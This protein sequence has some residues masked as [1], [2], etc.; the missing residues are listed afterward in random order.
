VKAAYFSPMPPERSGIA[1]YSA[2]LVPELAKRVELHVVERGARR[3]PRGTDA[4]VYHVGNDAEHH[5]WIVEALRGFPSLVVLHE[6]VL[7]HLVAGMTLGRGDRDGY[8][9]A[10]Q[11][12]AGPA[13]RMLAHGVVD[14]LV[15]PLWE[16][17]PQDF[18][19][20]GEIFPW[21][22]ALVVHSATVERMVRE[23][24]YPGPIW[25]IPHPAWRVPPALPDPELP[26][27]AR[28]GPVIGCF[29]HLNAS[30]RMPQL[31]AAFRRVV[32]EVP[33]AALLVVGPATPELQLEARIERL[34]L[35]GRVVRLGYVDEPL[36]WPLLERC[37]VVTN[38]R[39]P[40]M[41]ETS[42]IALR[43][44]SMGRPLVVSDV[45][46]FS[47]LPDTVAAKV[48]VDEWEIDTLAAT[49]TLLCSNRELRDAMGRAG[50]DLATRSHD[51][52]A[53]AERYA[54]A[55]ELTAGGYEMEGRVY[56]ELARAA[57]EVGIGAASDELAAIRSRLAEVGL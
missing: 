20:V 4:A 50:L 7:H 44:M 41:G 26:E 54:A 46:W 31:L 12:D 51:V 1:D 33:D 2:L 21:A 15:P 18:P 14:G 39:W 37:A 40:T 56:G 6:A 24:G 11:R 57:A 3:P 32:D 42:G 47:E 43:A 28:A 9:G 8:L 55:I 52:G 13:G 29:G 34:G 45:G 16:T 25:R 38:L 22:R 27:L 10:M 17:C 35:G 19:L 36:L 53:V 49:L 48:P 30:K 5:G 23:R